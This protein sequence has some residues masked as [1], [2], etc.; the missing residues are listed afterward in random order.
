[1][2]NNLS[3]QSPGNKIAGSVDLPIGNFIDIDKLPSMKIITGYSFTTVDENVFVPIL[4]PIE[5][6]AKHLGL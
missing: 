1:M 4:L 3:E 5:Y 2:C 6:I